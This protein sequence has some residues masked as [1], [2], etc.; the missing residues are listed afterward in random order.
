MEVCVKDIQNERDNRRISID[1]VGI[2]KLHY[3]VVVLDQ[4]NGT[5]QTTAEIDMSV[6]LPHSSRGTHMSRFLEVLNQHKG[7]VTMTTMMPILRHI[8]ESLHASRAEMSVKFP[9]FLEKRAPVSQSRS[10]LKYDCQF[11]GAFDGREF[12]FVLSVMVPVTTLCP[13]S[14]ALS[15]KSAHNQRSL[16]S[17]SLRFSHMIWIEEVIHWVEESASADIFSLLK[18]EDEKFLTEK[19]YANPRFAEDL[20]REIALRLNKHKDVIWYTVE[21]ENFESIHAHSAYAFIE[22]DKHSAIRAKTP[23]SR[24]APA[25]AEQA[26]TPRP[27]QVKPRVAAPRVSKGQ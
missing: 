26:S 23:R 12:D 14:K 19:A 16:V 17:V 4:V 10:L 13:C 8:L 9:Y 20:V 27:R 25:A 3:P 21:T 18:R 11:Y 7:E 2:K 24:P 22:K 1:K 15:A 6:D 5:Q